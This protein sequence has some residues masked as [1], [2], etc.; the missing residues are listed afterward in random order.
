VHVV[1]YVLGFLGLVAG[2]LGVV[3]PVVPASLLLVAGTAAIAW[4]NGF[5]RVGWGTVVFSGVIAALVWSVDLVAAVLGT[6]LVK[7][8][9]W[10]VV[11]AGVGLLVGFF[12]GPPGILLGPAVGAV[13]FEYARNPDARH[14]LR[15][16]GGAFLGF[17]LGSAVKVALSMALLGFVALRLLL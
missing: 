3:V 10:A 13:V 15:A 14:A 11:G 6:K 17:V 7:A 2:V 9:R 8:S 5:A 1:G 4:A 16:G 12:F